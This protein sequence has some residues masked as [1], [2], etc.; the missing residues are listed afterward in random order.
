MDT[1][2]KN[3]RWG[4]VKSRAQL[5]AAHGELPVPFHATA[6]RW[7]PNV[8]IVALFFPDIARVT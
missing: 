3:G 1:P 4:H 7:E 6:T 8:K 5:L 2:E